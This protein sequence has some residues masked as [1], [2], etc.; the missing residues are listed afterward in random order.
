[1]ASLIA[2][3]SSRPLYEP[4]NSGRQEIRRLKL[5]PPPQNDT[6]SHCELITH[7]LLDNPEDQYIALS[8][9]WGDP[10]ITKEII[11]NG[12]SV[13]VTINL[14]AALR[15]IQLHLSPASA[16]EGESLD[17]PQY[18]WADAL[19][20]NQ[21]DLVEKGQQVLMMDRIY[22][23]ASLVIS[24][25]G[26][27][28]D[29]ISLA[30]STL[31]LLAR[32]IEAREDS[33]QDI[34]WLQRFPALWEVNAP[35]KR[36]PNRAWNAISLF[37]QHPYWSR[38]W[39]IQ[40]MV[41]AKKILIMDEHDSVDF[42]CLKTVVFWNQNTIQAP[43]FPRPVFFEREVW[44]AIA[45]QFNFSWGPVRT[46]LLLQ[47]YL[48]GHP[49]ENYDSTIRKLFFDARFYDATNP[50]DKIFGL[51]S[52]VKFDIRPDYT[53]T[54]REVYCGFVKEWKEMK[55]EIDTILCHSGLGLGNEDKFGLPSW[56]PDFYAV[57][58]RQAHSGY[59]GKISVAVHEADSKLAAFKV[60]ASFVD[61]EDRLH[62][63]GIAIDN[64][65]KVEGHMLPR[66]MLQ[67]CAEYVS[68]DPKAK[69]RTSIPRL[70]AVFRLLLEGTDSIDQTD[71][72]FMYER[73]IELLKIIATSKVN[74]HDPNLQRNWMDN[75]RLLPD[76]IFADWYF[77]EVYPGEKHY[78]DL[79]SRT[80]HDTL[81]FS[82]SPALFATAMSIYIGLTS[83]RIFQTSTGYLGLGGKLMLAGD[84]ICVVKGCTYPVIL[85]KIEDYHVHVGTCYV[86]GLMEGEAVEFLE[87]GERQLQEFQ[88]R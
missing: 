41:L 79:P 73:I 32:E 15:S 2:A 42:T 85:R 88:I 21:T 69:Y 34:E 46:I 49:D 53:R 60:P 14:A 61:P 70:Q 13:P 10:N 19:C 86:L 87:S 78:K 43:N 29:Q 77:A 80:I 33:I 26:S 28:D 5:L 12:V 68:G 55:G 20:I 57:S 16:S 27:G 18:L 66:D 76:R 35:E 9:V 72:R 84:I 58:Y 40:E 37:L 30:T 83:C 7:S 6:R 67:Y 38:I 47:R 31:K 82:S 71:N 8:Y 63:H 1:M 48:E 75:I 24:W 52:L 36:V 56:V 39:I 11:V 23:Q 4:L 44:T 51:L 64:V 74:G 65:Q 3:S 62:I 45:H 81:L 22:T 50:R 17:L 59:S 25:L 54:V